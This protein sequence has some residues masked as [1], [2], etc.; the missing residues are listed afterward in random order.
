M[1]ASAEKIIEQNIAISII[2]APATRDHAGED[3][4]QAGPNLA[5]AAAVR[6]A[7]FDCRPPVAMIVSAPDCGGIA[8]QE[9]EASAAYCRRRPAT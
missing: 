2:F 4:S 3:S 7:K 9:T 6:R 8:E 1:D 5:A